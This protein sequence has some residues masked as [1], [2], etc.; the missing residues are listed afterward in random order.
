MF[1]TR[2]TNFDKAID[3]IFGGINEPIWKTT[4][5]SEDLNKGWEVKNNILYVA[6]P[7]H[8]KEDLEINIDGRTLTISAEVSSEDENPFKKTFEKS[9]TLSDNTSTEDIVAAME[10]GLLSL[11]FGK[12]TEK[13]KVK[14]S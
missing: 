9:W 8:T 6:L 14:I 13:K 4:F 12:S 1:T 2:G 11:T 3:S 5:F 10:N 7:G